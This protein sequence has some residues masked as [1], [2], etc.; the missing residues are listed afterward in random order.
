MLSVIC[1]SLV[2]FVLR[3][4]LPPQQDPQTLEKKS[5]SPMAFRRAGRPPTF[6]SGAAVELQEES[7]T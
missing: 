1:F 2:S 3:G 4:C 5:E 7:N 6:E